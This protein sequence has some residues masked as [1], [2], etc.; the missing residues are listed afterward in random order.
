MFA[1]NWSMSPSL[2]PP[3]SL[4]TDGGARV[5]NNGH[6]LQPGLIHRADFPPPDRYLPQ[7]LSPEDDQRLDQE[8][9]LIDDL[10]SNALRLIRATG[11]RIGECIDLPLDC[12]RQVGEQLW[13]LHVPLGKLHT[14][15]FVP[16]DDDIRYIVARILTLRPGS[17]VLLGAV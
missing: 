3:S 12:L 15:R 5:D 13:A 6:A 4:E 16:V 8:L 1:P 14:E 17:Y 2:P 11:V 10:Q 7:P 9:C